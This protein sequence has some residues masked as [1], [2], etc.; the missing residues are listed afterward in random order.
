LGFCDSHKDLKNSDEERVEFAKYYLEDYR[1][2]Y[3]DAEDDNQK[4]CNAKY[5][6]TYISNDSQNWRGLFRSPLILKTFAA[7]FSCT[8]G[9]DQNLYTDDKSS[10]ANGALGL[11]AASVRAIRCAY[12]IILTIDRLRG[13]Y[14]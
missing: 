11:S 2:L 7:H 9:T 6:A 14:I 10:R 8:D 12:D 13:P 3:E 4:V 1:F 5:L